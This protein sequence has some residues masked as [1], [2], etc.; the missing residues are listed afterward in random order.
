MR[1]ADLGGGALLGEG[2]AASPRLP[3][4]CSGSAIRSAYSLSDL[5]FPVVFLLRSMWFSNGGTRNGVSLW[6]DVKCCGL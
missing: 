2:S 4:D 6:T 3:A 5:E 1:R